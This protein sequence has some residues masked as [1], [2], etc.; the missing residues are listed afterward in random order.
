M[1]IAG[2]LVSIY[3]LNW[4]K[5]MKTENYVKSK[6]KLMLSFLRARGAGLVSVSIDTRPI[7]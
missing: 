2:S 7:V 5:I 3:T 1:Y 6:I 4:C